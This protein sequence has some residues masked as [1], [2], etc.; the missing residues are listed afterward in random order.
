LKMIE[1]FNALDASKE[2]T[3]APEVWFFV[4]LLDLSRDFN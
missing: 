2:L 4:K 3:A 1:E